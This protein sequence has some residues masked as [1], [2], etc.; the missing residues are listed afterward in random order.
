MTGYKEIADLTSYELNLSFAKS[1][2]EEG[3]KLI[4][5]VSLPS[6]IRLISKADFYKNQQFTNN[7]KERK[8]ISTSIYVENLVYQINASKKIGKGSF[9]SVYPC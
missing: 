8:V 4:L 6:K 7:L 3:C 9:G 1:S 2:L 5:T